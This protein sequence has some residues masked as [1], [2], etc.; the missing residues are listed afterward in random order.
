MS[1]SGL[2]YRVPLRCKEYV[3]YKKHIIDDIKLWCIVE[4]NKYS[5]YYRYVGEKEIKS[6]YIK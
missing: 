1:V 3:I 5:T 4:H 2:N 6:N